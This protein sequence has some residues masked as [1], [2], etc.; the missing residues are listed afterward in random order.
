[1]ARRMGASGPWKK[2]PECG[3]VARGPQFGAGFFRE[4]NSLSAQEAA[5]LVWRPE[6]L[7]LAMDAAS[8]ALWSWQVDTDRFTM[9]ERAFRLWG[10]AWAKE[11]AFEELS[12]H[13]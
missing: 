3:Q 6:H 9:D 1:M 11:V 12:A 4:F 13:C 8:V 2:P 7:R 10:L 5:S